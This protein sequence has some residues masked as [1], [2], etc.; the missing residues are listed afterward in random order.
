MFSIQKWVKE[1]VQLTRQLIRSQWFPLLIIFGFDCALNISVEDAM[2]GLAATE[3]TQR[4]VLQLILGLWDLAEGILLF[5]ILSYGIPKVRQ[6]NVK[7]MLAKPF[8]TPYLGSFLAEYLRMLA[9]ILMWGLLLILPGFWRYM[10]LIFVP[11]V[12]LFAREYRDEDADAMRLSERLA[13]GRLVKY[14]LPV[15]VVTMGLQTWFEFLPEMRPVLHV[16]PVRAAFD[17]LTSLISVWSYSLIFLLFE[18]ALE[19]ADKDAKE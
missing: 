10:Q 2:Q 1:S 19:A 7:T 8:D 3:E 5:L 17:V 9:Q 4:W 12:A 13:R 15:V 16:V 6:L 11:L 14:I 18:H